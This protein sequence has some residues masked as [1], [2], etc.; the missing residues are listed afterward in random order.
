[1]KINVF[2]D[3]I[4]KRENKFYYFLYI[5]YKKIKQAEIFLPKF[6]VAFFYSE[7]LLRKNVCHWMFSKMYYEPMVRYCCTAVGKNLKCDG[8][9]PLIDGGGTIIIGNN[10]FIGNQGAWFVSPNL[11]PN[12][13]L[14]IGNNTVLNYRTVI[15]VEQK[16]QIGNNCLIAEQVKI[17]D[18][19]SHG[20]DYNN[21][22][23]TLSD[24][25]PV[26]IEDNV[27]IGM[28]SI[29]LKGVTIG[30]GAVVAAGSVVTKDVDAM[31]VVAGNPAKFIKSIEKT[32]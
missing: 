23:M 32:N 19:N 1:M 7:R 2:I 3:R 22:S 14:K 30:K 27:W 29:I 6:L 11:Y 10:V 5:S 31:T 24:V 9:M 28:N 26:I 21:R 12:P 15:S 8:D 13:I 16:V 4:R 18:N 25:N 17:Y 20:I